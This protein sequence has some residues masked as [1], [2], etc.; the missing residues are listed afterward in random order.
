VMQRTA[1]RARPQRVNETSDAACG[2]RARRRR[3]KETS[4]AASGAAGK[5]STRERNELCS[6]RHGGRDVS[7]SEKRVMQLVARR[8]TPRR[9][10][11]T[12]DAASGTAGK[13]SARETNERRSER[14]GGQDV[15][16]KRKRAL[17]QAARA[18]CRQDKE[19]SNAG[20][21]TAGKTS[22]RERNEI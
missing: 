17:Q 21:G 11:E 18:S 12:R 1:R 15:G 16:E 8:A 19:T 10:I 6:E 2:V 20:S 7:K 5:T 4:T 14:R 3:E 9:M 22:A 13:M